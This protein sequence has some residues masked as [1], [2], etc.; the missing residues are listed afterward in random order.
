MNFYHW[1]LAIAFMFPF[2]PPH[3][4]RQ[5][6]LIRNRWLTLLPLGVIGVGTQDDAG[7]ARAVELAASAA[8]EGARS[9]MLY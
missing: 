4:W 5:W 8:L 3:V 7:G 1:L 6:P 9:A 2:A